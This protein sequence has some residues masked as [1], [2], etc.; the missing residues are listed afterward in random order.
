LKEQAKHGKSKINTNDKYVVVCSIY[1]TFELVNTLNF[2]IIY[3]SIF[4]FV[5]PTYLQIC[6]SMKT[7]EMFLHGSDVH[8]MCT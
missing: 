3:M 7:T 4:V 6:L 2:K 8:I 5:L 1:R